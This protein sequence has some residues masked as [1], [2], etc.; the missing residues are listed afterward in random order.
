MGD[1]FMHPAIFSAATPISLEGEISGKGISTSL[2]QWI[3][4]L[5][6][7]ARTN[8]YLVGHIKVFIE[9]EQNL[10]LSATGGP[11][12][13]RPSTQWMEWAAKSF[14]LYMTAIVFG[15]DDRSLR[16]E[17]LNRFELWRQKL[18]KC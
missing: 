10:W 18:E 16:S 15:I 8:G 7:W 12:N 17:V 9:G 5:Q 6:Q 4:G 14:T 13:L 1:P 3:D 11:V 2:T